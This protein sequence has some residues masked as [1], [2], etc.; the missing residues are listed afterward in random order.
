MEALMIRSIMHELLA[1]ARLLVCAAGLTGL[2]AGS[3][4]AAG[5]ADPVDTTR[6]PWTKQCNEAAE[7][8]KQ[9]CLTSHVL[10]DERGTL[11]AS[12]AVE[13]VSGRTD[14]RLLVAVPTGVRLT[15]GM[16]LQVDDT[17]S[18]KLDYRICFADRCFADMTADSAFLG[19]MR[20]GTN[21]KVGVT[22]ASQKPATLEFSLAGFSSILDSEAAQSLQPSAR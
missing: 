5:R 14:P 8:E 9:T 1:T 12:L 17:L 22:D 11:I 7:G 6:S 16:V 3:A 15:A 4:Q 13:T 10:F 21:F 19:R 2:L 20:R 18:R